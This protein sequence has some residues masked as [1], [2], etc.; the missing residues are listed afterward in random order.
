M[1]NYRRFFVPGGTYFFTLVTEG[2]SGFLC[3]PP[4]R[5][6]LT[7]V[8]R[9]LSA[10]LAVPHLGRGAPAG[11][12]PCRSGRYR[13]RMP[14]TRVVGR[15]SSGR[16][17][18]HG[19]RQAERSSRAVIHAVRTDGVALWQ[20]LF[21]EHAIFD[22][23]DYERHVEY[24]H[25]NPVKHGHARCPHAWPYSSFARFVQAGFYPLDW[26]CSCGANAMPPPSFSSLEDRAGETQGPPCGP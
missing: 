25:Y 18:R 19:W 4:A 5:A 10:S 23:E 3:E 8:D 7:T 6:I 26:A 16:S 20:R 13:H 11:S 14:T 9:G 15:A 2:R 12:Y 1:P 21:L 17:R 22:E 24:I